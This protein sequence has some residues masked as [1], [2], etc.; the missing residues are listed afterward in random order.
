MVIFSLVSNC[1]F[2]KYI[3]KLNLGFTVGKFCDGCVFHGKIRDF[4]WKMCRG[5]PIKIWQEMRGKP[6][7]FGGFHCKCEHFWTKFLGGT[8]SKC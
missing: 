7:I 3:E 8:L 2:K 6:W 4:S 5:Y 1:E